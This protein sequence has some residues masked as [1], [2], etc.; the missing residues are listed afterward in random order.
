LGDTATPEG[1]FP[2]VIVAVTVFVAVLITDTEPLCKFV[3]YTYSPFGVIATLAGLLPR[4]IVAVTVFVAVLITD[5]VP[6]R[7]LFVT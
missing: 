7:E 1:E 4:G 6:L 5:T 3:T 2:T